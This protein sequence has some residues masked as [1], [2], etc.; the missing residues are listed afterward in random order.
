MA[1]IKG[2]LENLGRAATGPLNGTGKSLLG[3]MMGTG[4]AVVGA[5]VT[6]TGRGAFWMIKQPIAGAIDIL[7]FGVKA[8]RKHKVAALVIAGTGTAVYFANHLRDSA[9]AQTQQQLMGQ[10]M[11]QQ[12]AGYGPAI[13]PEEYAQMEARMKQGSAGQT[14]FAEAV[15]AKREAAAATPASQTAPAV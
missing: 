8:V 11:G 1:S 5:A 15:T 14:G 12:P 9:A 4:N 7:G 13:T 10:A 2:S 3:R 6:Q